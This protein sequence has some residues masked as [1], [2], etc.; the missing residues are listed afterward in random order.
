MGVVWRICMSSP[1]KTVNFKFAIER[2]QEWDYPHY[3]FQT[4]PLKSV[5]I[6]FIVQQQS[7]F[8]P[9]NIGWMLHF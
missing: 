8:F 9:E 5:A 4:N 3:K 1:A 2:E 6:A 7:F